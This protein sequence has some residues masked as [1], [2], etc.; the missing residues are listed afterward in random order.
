M[1]ASLLIHRHQVALAGPGLCVTREDA[2]AYYPLLGLIERGSAVLVGETYDLQ[3]RRRILAQLNCGPAHGLGRDEERRT[4]TV[5][6]EF[7]VAA[8]KD[9]DDWQEKW[10]REAVQNS[11][12]AGARH[13][14]LEVRENSD[15]TF[16]ASCEDNG[17]G[18]DEDTLINKFLVLGATTKIATGGT[19]GGFGKAKELLLLPWMSWRIHS[20]DT[21]VQGS[22]ID[23]TVHRLAPRRGT[24][25]EV[26]M[27]ADKHTY[28]SA[29]IAFI[30]KCFLPNVHFTVNGKTYRAKLA[31]QVLVES[32]A[33]KADVYFTPA[34][35][36]Q[37]YLYVRTNGLFMFARHIGQVP[38]YVIAEMTVPSVQVLTANRD[39][40]RDYEI[41][42]AVDELA[43]RIAKDNMSALKSSRGLIRQKFVGAGKF[44]ATNL[45]SD[46]LAQ[47]G[48]A[49]GVQVISLSDQQNIVAMID[50]YRER[51]MESP[52][53]ESALPATETITVML[54]QKW[55]GP[56]HL[57]AA[58]KQL[59]WQPDFF[60]VNEIDGYKVPKRFFPQTMAPT[61]NKL[62]KTWA[63]LVRYVMM[64]LGSDK[65][66]GVGFIFSNDTGAAA[67]TEDNNERWLMVNPFRDLYHRTEIWHPTVDADLR[68][69]YAAAIH[70][71]THIA[72]GISYHDE[73][74]SSA[75]TRNVAKCAG[76]YRKIRA[77]VSGIKM[78][79]GI[80]VD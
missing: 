68:W 62:A 59:V 63:E 20:R 29:A 33:G 54:D 64:Q 77:I 51:D 23:Y 61:V 46:L 50:H 55:D 11:V 71:C 32:V 18:M 80:E 22:G 42:N 21:G 35:D 27:S 19:A 40:F 12:D 57:E 65:T 73:S 6:P 69:L 47:V 14:V 70:E 38:G 7:F 39:G 44:R 8:L 36:K 53:H 41:R 25:L 15:G 2:G 52:E 9:Y 76:G 28:E 4:I 10:W 37:S 60:I 56:S 31:G 26:V 67:L 66:F 30:E 72:D 75:M 49:V 45:A 34:K 13:V 58:L 48:P 1:Q 5:G 16:T 17:S 74:F 3:G 43:Q 78:R 24:R 79:G